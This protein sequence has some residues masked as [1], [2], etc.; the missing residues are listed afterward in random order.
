M[1]RQH[2]RKHGGSGDTG[3]F[4]EASVTAL[5]LSRDREAL[6]HRLAQ[7]LAAALV[8]EI[9]VEDAAAAGASEDHNIRH[10]TTGRR[11]RDNREGSLTGLPL[12]E[13]QGGVQ[14]HRGLCDGDV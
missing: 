14:D 12:A 6:D 2:V 4:V 10:P 7:H 5:V 3:G 13:T 8:R 9:R 1:A 11:R